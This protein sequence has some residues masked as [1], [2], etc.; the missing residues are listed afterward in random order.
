VESEREEFAPVEFEQGPELLLSVPPKALREGKN[1][2]PK[3]S[4]HPAYAN[5]ELYLAWFLLLGEMQE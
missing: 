2:S 3:M 5:Q 4:G 1:S